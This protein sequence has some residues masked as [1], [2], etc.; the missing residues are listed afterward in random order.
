MTN[1]IIEQM[2][3]HL[4]V[5]PIELALLRKQRLS[6]PRY[7]TISLHS[8]SASL[9]DDGA[10]I[11]VQVNSKRLALRLYAVVVE[12]GNHAVYNFIKDTS[13]HPMSKSIDL[14]RITRS[15]LLS[16]PTL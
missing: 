8:G 3:A 7:A 14:R 15:V 4:G 12:C 10:S 13:K 5:L 9:Y 6:C 2:L 11:Y 16:R 1:G